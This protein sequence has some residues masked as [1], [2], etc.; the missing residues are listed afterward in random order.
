VRDPQLLA[1]HRDRSAQ[2]IA[3]ALTGN[4]RDEHLFVLRQNFQAYQESQQQLAECDRAIERGA[5]GHPG[6]QL[7]ATQ[8]RT[9]AGA[10]AQPTE[11][12]QAA[13][14]VALAAASDHRAG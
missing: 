10:T 7:R 8:E 2:E 9:A 1:A 4:Y 11:H 3:A 14:G 6:A 5:T 13:P 12:E